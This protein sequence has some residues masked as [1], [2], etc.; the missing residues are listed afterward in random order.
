MPIPGTIAGHCKQIQNVIDGH[1]KNISDEIVGY[2]KPFSHISY[3]D[4][5]NKFSLKLNVRK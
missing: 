1:Y 3:C 4:Q 2:C 5:K